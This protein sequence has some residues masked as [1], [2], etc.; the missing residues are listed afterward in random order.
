[1]SHNYG[2]HLQEVVADVHRAVTNLTEQDNKDRNQQTRGRIESAGIQDEDRHHLA[3]RVEHLSERAAEAII[4]EAGPQSDQVRK[5]ELADLAAWR[6]DDGYTATAQEVAERRASSISEQENTA[7]AIGWEHEQLDAE[8]RGWGAA[9]RADTEG[10]NS[11]YPTAGAGESLSDE[12]RALAHIRGRTTMGKFAAGLYDWSDE[13]W[14]GAINGLTAAGYPVQQVHGTIADD[15][16]VTRG[17]VFSDASDGAV[18]PPERNPNTRK[19][20][21]QLR[22]PCPRSRHAAVTPYWPPRRRRGCRLRPLPPSGGSLTT[23]HTCGVT[24]RRLRSPMTPTP[25]T[26]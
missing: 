26:G 18:D 23:T 1:M 2:Y 11:A 14:T 3:E 16:T 21:L 9:T 4:A 10:G 6:S 17:W 24:L 7:L 15:P 20:H 13:R 25:R 19:P 5:D 8:R 22:S 12:R